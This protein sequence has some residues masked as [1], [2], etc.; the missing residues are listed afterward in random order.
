M[1]DSDWNVRLLRWSTKFAVLNLGDNSEERKSHLM[2]LPL[3]NWN[4]PEF[5][6]GNTY[7]E[8]VL[9][10]IDA[11]HVVLVDC[12]IEWDFGAVNLWTI[13][14]VEREMNNVTTAWNKGWQIYN[15]LVMKPA[16]FLRA[17]SFVSIATH[18]LGVR[19]DLEAIDRNLSVPDD[20]LR[21]SYTKT[22]ANKCIHCYSPWYRVGRRLPPRLD[23]RPP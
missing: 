5:F 22:N 20:L 6:Y 8:V 11:F 7:L 14:V 23:H 13:F 3:N 15:I 1:K 16:D 19:V 4:L 21:H 9:L 17:R 10:I 12:Q 18:R 2:I